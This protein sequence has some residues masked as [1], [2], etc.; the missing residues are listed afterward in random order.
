MKD[1]VLSTQYSVP[2]TQYSVLSTQYSVLSTQYSDELDAGLTGRYVYWL[3][4]REPLRRSFGIKDLAG[5]F[6]QVFEK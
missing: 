6:C 3:V 2:S 4:P 1:S 5:D